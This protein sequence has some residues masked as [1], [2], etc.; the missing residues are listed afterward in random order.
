MLAQTS[1]WLEVKRTASQW[2]GVVAA[3]ILSGLL[4]GVLRQQGVQYK[5]ALEMALPVGFLLA[6]LF[7]IWI[8]SRFAVKAIDIP[9]PVS[10]TIPTFEGQLVWEYSFQ[11]VGPTLASQT[12]ATLNL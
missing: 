2:T 8:G 1:F 6:L 10:A 9:I 11:M 7:W 5:P 3:S 12:A 4:L